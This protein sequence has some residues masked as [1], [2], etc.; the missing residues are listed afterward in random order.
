MPNSHMQRRTQFCSL[1]SKKTTTDKT[2]GT[3]RETHPHAATHQKIP[4]RQVAAAFSSCTISTK[5]RSRREITAKN[6]PEIFVKCLGG[7][8]ALTSSGVESL[9]YSRPCATAEEGEGV[10]E[11]T[12]SGQGTYTSALGSESMCL[13]RLW[14]GWGSP[15]GGEWLVYIFVLMDKIFLCDA[16][17]IGLICWYRNHSEWTLSRFNP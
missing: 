15:P 8:S 14:C 3:Q 5:K 6:I 11:P 16:K 13:P 12:T 1:S 2:L 9:L 4:K 7:R 10:S 17:K